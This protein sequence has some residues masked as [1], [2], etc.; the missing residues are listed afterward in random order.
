MKRNKFFLGIVILLFIFSACAKKAEEPIA[1]PLSVQFFNDA[2][3]DYSI[4]TIEIRSRGTIGDDNQN[5]GAWGSNLL[6]GGLILDPGSS[7]TFTLDI[8]NLEWSEYRISVDD[9]NG[10]TVLVSTNQT[11]GI[12]GALPISHVGSNNRTVS[13]E[14]KYNANQDGIYISSWSDFSR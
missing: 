12:Q 3:S 6:T 1:D 9:G 7:T 4:N 5:I 11:F 2:N 10:N 14:V 13:V 8:P